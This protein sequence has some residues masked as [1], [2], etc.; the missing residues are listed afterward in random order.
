MAET[1]IL[2]APEALSRLEAGEMVLIDIRSPDEWAETGV[3]EGAWPVSMH[4]KDFATRLQEILSAYS[5]DRIALICAT[6][7]RTEYVTKVLRQNG[8]TG[9]ADVSEG[10]MGNGR[11]AGWIERGMS[12]TDIATAA[13]AYEAIRA[14]W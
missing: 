4:E 6:G 7:G 10:M 12:V 5:P 11:G 14:D 9:V 1:P 3:A 2:S 8:I 13:K